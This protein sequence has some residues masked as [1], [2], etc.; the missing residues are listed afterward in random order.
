[1]AVT[2]T[3]LERGDVHAAVHSM[4]ERLR[5]RPRRRLFA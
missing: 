3:W 2:K 4:L 1:M 5:T